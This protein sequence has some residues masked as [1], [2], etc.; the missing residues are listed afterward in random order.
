MHPGH[1]VPPPPPLPHQQYN[2]EYHSPSSYMNHHGHRPRY[3][4]EEI[5]N[6]YRDVENN[7][8]VKRA[9]KMVWQAND[10]YDFLRG[11]SWRVRT[12][13]AGRRRRRS[14][15]GRPCQ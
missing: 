5:L 14:S 9:K 7:E 1:A 6:S 2:Q 13:Q 10:M 3:S 11:R 4:P 12:T 15:S 8:I